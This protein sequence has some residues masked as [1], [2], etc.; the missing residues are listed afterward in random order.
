MSTIR[1]H[2][3]AFPFASADHTKTANWRFKEPSEQQPPC[4]QRTMPS[5]SQ[6]RL[7]HQHYALV[8]RRQGTTRVHTR[9]QSHA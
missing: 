1:S 5:G 9:R 7:L 8:S 3:P 6:Q 2:L 4:H